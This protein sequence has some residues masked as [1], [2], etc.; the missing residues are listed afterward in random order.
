MTNYIDQYNAFVE[1]LEDIFMMDHEE[2]D[3]GIYRIMNYKRDEIKDF[4]KN[5]LLNQVDEILAKNVGGDQ[6]ALETELDTQLGTL[7]RMGFSRKEA[8]AS[9]PIMKL[10]EKMKRFRPLAELKNDV[11]SGLVTFFSRYYKGGDFISQRRYKSDDTYAIP[12]NGLRRFYI[13]FPLP[14]CCKKHCIHS[15]HYH[16]QFFIES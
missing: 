15:F 1:T 3:F 14:N 9:G 6:L 8:E 16:G 12:Y 7:E 10:R 11:Y 2:L 4:L 5:R 13:D